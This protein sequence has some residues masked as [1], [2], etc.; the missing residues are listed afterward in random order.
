MFLLG[1]WLG[2]DTPS[3]LLC[4]GRLGRSCRGFAKGAASS[5][6]TSDPVKSPVFDAPLSTGAQGASS[7]QRAAISGL[8]GVAVS[9]NGVA[10]EEVFHRDEQ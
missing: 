1:C 5:A 2:A 10:A 4:P 6:L 7:G 3:F 8:S 9:A